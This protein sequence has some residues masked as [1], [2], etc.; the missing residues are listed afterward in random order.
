MVTAVAVLAVFAALVPVAK[1][2]CG[3]TWQRA[4][5]HVAVYTAGALVGLAVTAWLGLSPWLSILPV[6]ACDPLARK[7]APL[8]RPAALG[9]S[10]RPR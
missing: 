1:A 3:C 8:P 5:S 4:A 2:L 9:G 10:R 7:V 6:L